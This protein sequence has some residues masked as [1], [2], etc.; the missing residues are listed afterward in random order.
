MLL[1]GNGTVTGTV[2]AD[3]DGD[4]VLDAEDVGYANATVYVD[5]N[6]NSTF[7]AADI[8]STTT[9]TSGYYTFDVPESAAD[10]IIRVVKPDTNWDITA[11]GN[12]IYVLQISGGVTYNNN[13]FGLRPDLS[14]SGNLAGNYTL[15]ILAPEGY[16]YT[17]DLE[18]PDGFATGGWTITWGDGDSD[19]VSGATA[20]HR[21]GDINSQY[22]PYTITAT[23]TD[24]TYTFNSDPLSVFVVE[25]ASY[26][27]VESDG[28]VAKVSE[29]IESYHRLD[30]VDFGSNTVSQISVN[31]GD[32][33][34]IT[35]NQE[36]VSGMWHGSEFNILL[37]PHTYDDNGTYNAVF[38]VYRDGF[39]PV[40]V[41]KSINVEDVVPNLVPAEDSANISVGEVY[42]LDITALYPN[43]LDDTVEQWEVFWGDGTSEN[44]TASGT[45][46]SF[47]H[48]YDAAGDYVI[49]I[50]GLDIDGQVVDDPNDVD[51]RL[52]IQWQDAEFNGLTLHAESI[53]FQAVLYSDGR[54]RLAYEDLASSHAGAEGATA[55]AGVSS[56]ADD[57]RD[58]LAFYN[59]AKYDGYVP[60]SSHPAYDANNPD[61]TLSYA[62]PLG[63]LTINGNHPQFVGSEIAVAGGTEL[64]GVLV[65]HTRRKVGD[66]YV[67]DAADTPIMSFN[68]DV[69]TSSELLSPNHKNRLIFII[70]DSGDYV[71][72]STAYISALSGVPLGPWDLN[73]TA[74]DGHPITVTPADGHQDVQAGD[75]V[76]YNVTIDGTAEAKN[77]DL[78]IKDEL[79]NVHGSVPVKLNQTYFTL[80][81]ATDPDGN[82]ANLQYEFVGNSHGAEFVAGQQGVVSWDPPSTG[83]YSVRVRVT[84]EQGLSAERDYTIE[85]LPVD[86]SNNNPQIDNLPLAETMEV[87]I[88]DPIQFQVDASQPGGDNDDLYFYA[89]N[90]PLTGFSI[91]PDTGLIEWTPGVVETRDI[92]IHVADG[93]GGYDSKTLSVSVSESQVK[94]NTP[95]E[96]TVSGP[97]F[98]YAGMHYEA[99]LTIVNHE[100]DRLTFSFDN[101]PGGLTISPDGTKL[102]WESSESDIGNYEFLL[103]VS[104]GRG[105]DTVMVMLEVRD[106][107]LPPVLSPA[108]LPQALV[109]DDQDPST[110]DPDPYTFN[111]PVSD[112]NG[113]ELFYLI[114]DVSWG[115]GIR[116]EDGVLS[117]ANPQTEPGVI[118]T[119]PITVGVHDGK[120]GYD[121]QVYYLDV[122]P[123]ADPRFVDEPIDPVFL[124]EEWTYTIKAYD[125][126][127][128][129]SGPNN[130]NLTFTIDA[131]SI[132]RDVKIGE[133]SGDMSWTPSTTHSQ[134]VLVT[135]TDSFGNSNSVT[136]FL[137]V[138]VRPTENIPPEVVGDVKGPALEGREWSHT[139]V[140]KDDNDDLVKIELTGWPT[141]YTRS[142]EPV[143]ASYIA[144]STLT[145]TG[146]PTGVAEGGQ[147][148]VF[149]FTITDNNFAAGSTYDY[150]LHLAVMDNS[151]PIIVTADTSARALLGNEIDLSFGLVDLDGDDLHIELVS[152]APGTGQFLYAESPLPNGRLAGVSTDLA[153]PTTLTL[154]FTPDSTGLQ[155][156]IIRVT[157]SQNNSK[158]HKITLNVFEEIAANPSVQY[159]R[160]IQAG[161]EDSA[162]VVFDNPENIARFTHYAL[163]DANGDRVDTLTSATGTQGG[164]LVPDGM[165]I[166][167]TGQITWTPSVA[168]IG[169]QF[170]YRVVVDTDDGSDGLNEYTSGVITIEVVERLVNHDPVINP[171]EETTATGGEDLTFTATATDLDKDPLDW[172]LDDGPKTA[173]ITLDGR[174]R[175]SPSE[176]EYG[177]EQTATIRVDDRHGGSDV[178]TIILN[179]T[180]FTVP[181]SDNSPPQFT[182]QAPVPS[183][184][185]A[186]YTYIYP[187]SAIDTDPGDTIRF[188]LE[189]EQ[190]VLDDLNFTLTDNQDGTAQLVWV[191]PPEGEHRSFT[192]L[193]VD[194]HGLGTRQGVSITIGSSGGS[195]TDGTIDTQLEF[196]NPPP[197][198][199]AAGQ[200][201]E[202]ITGLDDTTGTP[203]LSFTAIKQSDNTEVSQNDIT[204]TGTDISWQTNASDA[205]E[206]FLVT[207]TAE[208]DGV[209]IGMTY[210]VRVVPESELVSPQIQSDDTLKAVAGEQYHYDVQVVD[211]NVTQPSFFLVN[212][213]GDLVRTI[214]DLTISESGRVSWDVPSDQATPL[215]FKVHVVDADGLT[216]EETFSIAIGPDEAPVV[217]LKNLSP[218][219]MV[220]DSVTFS[221]TARDDVAVTKLEL[222]ITPP[223]GSGLMPHTL[224]ITGKQLVEYD[225]SVFSSI[226]TIQAGDT[227]QVQ[228]IAYDG[229]SPVAHVTNSATLEVTFIDIDNKAPVL[230]LANPLPGPVISEP[231]DLLAWITDSDNNLASY[232]VTLTPT[233]GGTP[234]IIDNVDPVLPGGIGTE[235]SPARLATI[236]PAYLSNGSYKLRVYAEDTAFLQSPTYSWD[237]TIDSQVLSKLGNVA[238]SNTDLSVTVGGLPIEVIRMYDSYSADTDCDMGFGWSYDI[239]EGK[240]EM[241]GLVENEF[242]KMGV[243]GAGLAYGSRLTIKLPGGETLGFTATA[244][245]D[246]DGFSIIAFEPDF[247]ARGHKLELSGGGKSYE[248]PL[249][250]SYQY[251]WEGYHIP[252]I[253]SFRVYVDPNTGTFLQPLTGA[254]GAGEYAPLLSPATD[255]EAYKLTL[256]DQTEYYFSTQTG[257]LLYAID[258]LKNKIK[259]D[260]DIVVTDPSNREIDRIQISTTGGRVSEIRARDGDAVQYFYDDAGNMVGFR[261]RSGRWT[262]YG[263]DENLPSGFDGEHILT[264]VTKY[265]SPDSVNITSYDTILATT[266]VTTVRFTFDDEGKLDT[267][268]DAANVTVNVDYVYGPDYSV[269]QVT[270]DVDDRLTETV[271]DELGRAIRVIEKIRVEGAD[272]IYNISVYEYDQNDNVKV[273]WV[274]FEYAESPGANLRYT[275]APQSV[276]AQ[277]LMESTFD[278]YGRQTTETDALGNVTEYNNYDN[279]GNPREIKDP[280]GHITTYRYVDGNVDSVI[281]SNPG[282]YDRVTQFDANPLGNIEEITVTMEDGRQFDTVK[283]KYDNKGRLI[284]STEA[285]PDGS[286]S[287]LQPQTRYYRYDAQGNMIL[288]YSYEYDEA[289]GMDKTIVAY[290]EYDSEAHVIG[291]KRYTLPGKVPLE[292]AAGL[293]GY[294]PD[295]STAVE[296]DGMGRISK[297]T[298]SFGSVSYTFY[299]R[300]GLVTETVEQT[301]QWNG[302]S[303]D[304]AWIVSRTVYDALGRVKYVLDS[305]VV[306]DDGDPATVYDTVQYQNLIGYGTELSYDILGRVIETQRLKDLT[307]SAAE[308]IGPGSGLVA[309]T[310]NTSA[311][312]VIGKTETGYDAQ[313]Q[314]KYTIEHN[315]PTDG[316]D[317]LRT[318]YYYNPNGAQIGMLG[319]VIDVDGVDMRV[320]SITEYDA[321]G[322]QKYTTTGLA[323]AASDLLL[324]V[325]LFS[326]H[327]SIGEFFDIN[328]K[329]VPKTGLGNASSMPSTTH[330]EYDALGQLTLTTQEGDPGTTADDIV[331]ESKYDA[332]G[333]E[334]ATIDALGR[335]TN[336]EYDDAGRLTAV[337]LPQIEINDPAGSGQMIT[338]QPRYEYRYD[339]YG[340]QTA[341]IDN[342]YKLVSTGEVVYFKKNSTTFEDEIETLVGDALPTH[343]TEFEYDHLGRQT[344]RTLA[345]GQTETFKYNDDTRINVQ[346]GLA[347]EMSVGYGQLEYHVSFEGKVTAYRYDNR[348]GAGGRLVAEYYYDSLT[349]YD[350]ANLDTD[351]DGL[352]DSYNEA[353]FYTYDAHGRQIEVLFDRDG[354]TG[355]DPNEQDKTTYAYDDLG[356]LTMTAAP[357]GTI[358]YVYNDRGQLIRTYTGNEITST[359][360]TPTS[361]DGIGITD[362]EYQYDK[363]GQ[364]ISV[365]VHERFDDTTKGGDTTS[366]GYD[367]IGN[368][369]YTELSSG[370]VTDYQYDDHNRL[371]NVIQFVDVG[372]GNHVFDSGETIIAA[373][374]YGLNLDGTRASE[375]I[376]GVGS[377]TWTYDN[378]GRLKEESFDTSITGLDDYT[379]V[380]SFDLVGNRLSKTHYAT[381]NKTGSYDVTTY[382]YDNSD[383]LQAEELDNGDDG[384]IEKTTVYTYDET[385]QST[386]TVYIGTEAT[387]TLDSTTTFSYDLQ[388]R[389]KVS[390]LA[391][392]GGTTTTTTYEYN[393]QGIRVTEQVEQGAT[394]TKTTY[395][396]DVNNHTGYAQV[397]EEGVDGNGDG[398]IH[399]TDELKRVYT[400][401]HDVIAQMDSAG[402]TQSGYTVDAGDLLHLLTDGHGST[403]FVL[404][405]TTPAQAYLYDAYG[406]HLTGGTVGGATLGDAENAF[407]RLL[408][409]GEWTHTDGTQ[410]LR[411]RYYDPASGRFNRLD[412]F[413]GNQYDP[414][415]LHK[416]LYTHANP[417]MGTDPSGLFTLSEVLG[418]GVGFQS[419]EKLESANKKI[420]TS[421]RTA[422]VLVGI[423]LLQMLALA[424][425][426]P[427]LE[428][429]VGIMG[430]YYSLLGAN[431]LKTYRPKLKHDDLL[432]R[433]PVITGYL[434]KLQVGAE[435]LKSSTGYD[436][437]IRNFNFLPESHRKTSRST[438]IIYMGGRTRL[439]LETY[440]AASLR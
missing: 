170:T 264:S 12:G 288:T 45:S 191:D 404:D 177:K 437:K 377:Y 373:S 33:T 378:L 431:F 400:I 251:G 7:D 285:D 163:L 121:E 236:N 169:K 220:G 298:D 46:R 300:R 161:V 357:E 402:Q 26:D 13:D 82:D 311:I 210:T 83:S 330:F 183:N 181:G 265:P 256:P 102:F 15:D 284:Q 325:T 266:G 364:L 231:V 57:D 334:I 262:T 168:D 420:T 277:K 61:G 362:T 321:I 411:A 36:Q 64:N 320:L 188:R 136:L 78:Q 158:I 306:A 250:Y 425:T 205:N 122:G 93:R 87:T 55:T 421:V 309:T 238:L 317:N 38:T 374:I 323:I 153:S 434:A 417:I 326:M 358:H 393:A 40:T 269:E 345:D 416:Y 329:Y 151:P 48:I 429:V 209:T 390:A 255:A 195:S 337:N 290:T 154:R 289:T 118:T 276:N 305:Q 299:D 415:S 32:G 197:R 295:S 388:G 76:T 92:T 69:A 104:D 343:S 372:D 228:V 79:G 293:N 156:V 414:Q 148:D 375:L 129:D 1:S 218:A 97:E 241:S 376:F 259:F 312:A 381:A 382:T 252:D 438:W 77:F 303:Y 14:M 140:T 346:T 278:E 338:V 356:R 387:G 397:L 84:D 263:Y 159:R 160:K 261:D 141:W 208:L 42:E 68:H 211:D 30:I 258:P 119:Y 184:W 143:A 407:T 174:F 199:V 35:Y 132:A 189:G 424:R 44:I 202:Y 410:Y 440:S 111:L 352:L 28:P 296:Y 260:G 310:A 379:D 113:D 29:G 370:V 342:A 120:G 21:Y 67:L 149:T 75:A 58:A 313:G 178:R 244:I 125:A 332:L 350:A 275:V 230:N 233:E 135:V 396:I 240:M 322:Q 105:S 47:A 126:E 291:T 351:S 419:F 49:G 165:S 131:Q 5:V 73:L 235:E 418:V 368:L 282:G 439:R 395:L 292:T 99:D 85:V 225:F 3:R 187:I 229:A 384:S 283:Y 114:D 267:I 60:D 428:N 194:N 150:E 4:G 286:G 341:V 41:N 180:K 203:V 52:I 70:A 360:H 9:N 270:N 365:T 423:T 403:R 88:G 128:G 90:A 71:W 175:W 16:D 412:P 117:W 314:V 144:D 427:S 436:G 182:S 422:K 386:K 51:D 130:T 20:T 271:R 206:T 331:T 435:R 139:I 432:E 224:D 110:L 221:V 134:S 257:E 10:Q 340:N 43:G 383:R 327:P 392:N 248:I 27:G 237:I 297:S 302:S 103:T 335:Q 207:V 142:A 31:W 100:N 101:K 363:F 399:D 166:D 401:G 246:L 223:A 344:T 201:Y 157:D 287:G 115:L 145:L 22:V 369:D 274:P 196:K 50:S 349:Q 109:G 192:I 268:K 56:A 106:P 353:I 394:T 234:I 366:Y 204:I 198:K 8:Y 307:I 81:K 39:D 361:G 227:Y 190:A 281:S 426:I 239:L 138:N 116:V 155:H 59:I 152:P 172:Y 385:Q 133:H 91:D 34:S 371:L 213:A 430:V 319:P 226:A 318:D 162:Q 408:Y 146:T 359:P 98:I 245:P 164:A 23:A 66:T 86:A 53:T 405:G 398:D 185:G 315:D 25:T 333:R 409:S 406:N 380:Y 328:N 171:I 367:L 176:D 216:D 24:G 280:L 273:E 11:P 108:E 433:L 65:S 308:D 112:P 304:A 339:E 222:V 316:T 219:P 301:L 249:D 215:L 96:L 123:N 193:A 167:N 354:S 63:K 37:L 389:L 127:D 279:A 6:D 294:T 254:A 336:Y 18:D 272:T 147:V 2:F 200:S 243:F 232:T 95:P 214:G 347:P 242:T 17:I 413:A 54:V 186:G 107:N 62:D 72:D 355:S 391:I 94:V 324:D 212:D 173:S 19:T 179:A 137:P 253:Q 348:A 217:T 74:S 80:I 247:D 89:S 124:D